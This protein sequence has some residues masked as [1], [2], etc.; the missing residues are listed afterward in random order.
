M[1]SNLLKSCWNAG[2]GG[3]PQGVALGPKT[4]VNLLSPD[5]AA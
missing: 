1:Y 4:L 2:F 3:G 5:I